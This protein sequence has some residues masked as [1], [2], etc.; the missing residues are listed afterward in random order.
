MN[1]LRSMQGRSRHR[2]RLAAA[3]AVMVVGTVAEVGMPDVA[4]AAESIVITGG[5]STAETVCG[6]VAVAQQ[7]AL[8]RGVRIQ[9]NNCTSRA[10]GGTVTLSDVNIFLSAP[11]AS[12]AIA[13]LTQN[14]AGQT[15]DI[16]DPRRPSPGPG[17]QL[18]ICAGTGRA[19]AIT[20]NNVT[21]VYRDRDGRTSSP[22]QIRTE[23]GPPRIFPYV[24]ASCA[25]VNSYGP[26]QRDDCTG[27]GNG[28]AWD[29]R[30]VDVQ[31]PGGPLQRGID[32]VLRGGDADAVVR[33]FN[34]ADG[35]GRVLQMNRCNS[36]AQGGSIVLDNVT[37]VVEQ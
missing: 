17:F 16:C 29:V 30:N 23:S 3:V 35:G 20:L 14:R 34:T 32:V 8:R 11:A 33:C 36:V 37:F 13:R 4:S 18:N 22:R 15:R 25:R 5:D 24:S 12:Q 2:V 26:E 1:L 21:Q 9:R 7:F 28:S 19:G 31:R 6:N 10:D 27:G